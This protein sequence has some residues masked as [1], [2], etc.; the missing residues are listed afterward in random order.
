MSEE[1]CSVSEH[2]DAIAKEYHQQYTG[3]VLYDISRSYPA[4]YFRLQL[5]LNSFISK[6][7]KRVIEVGVGEGTPL[8][9]LGKAGFDVWGFDIS[10]EMV[11]KSKQAMK[12]SQLS[13]E[14][15]FW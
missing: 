11:K 9:T 6:G 8:A 12:A 10:H 3:E 2:Y 15:I 4:N 5:L 13:P 14:H 1:R 7:I